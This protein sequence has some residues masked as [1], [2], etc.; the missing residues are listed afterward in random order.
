MSQWCQNFLD[1]DNLELD[2]LWYERLAEA[3]ANWT[4]GTDMAREYYQRALQLDNPSWLCYRGLGKTYFQQNQPKEA[5]AQVQ[6]A[7]DRAKEKGATPEPK[8][9]DIVN[10]HLLL[11]QY[12]EEAED[13]Q[14]ATENFSIACERGSEDADQAR[15]AKLGL[16]KARLKSADVESTREWLRETPILDG[17]SM[18]SI[19]RTIALDDDPG[20]ILSKLFTVAKSDSIL[21]N[22]IVCALETATAGSAASLDGRPKKPTE[23]HFAEVEA[24]GVLLYYRG[25]AAYTMAPVNREYVGEALRLWTECRHLLS[26]VGGSNASLARRCSTTDLAKHYFQ[27]MLE[28]K[29]KDIDVTALST[30][31]ES[32]SGF[33][34]S[35]ALGFLGALYAMRGNMDESKKALRPKFDYAIQILEDDTP[36]NDSWGFLCLQETLATHCDFKNSA[37]ALSFLCQPDLVT[38]ALYFPR[39]GSFLKQYPAESGMDGQQLLSVL[40]ALGREINET[41][42]KQVPDSSQQAQRI[43]TARSY[44][45]SLQDA[46]EKSHSGKSG[47][48]DSDR[49]TAAA[50]NLVKQR[51]DSLAHSHMT[52]I[53]TDHFPMP[54]SCDGRT[55]DGRHC[56]KLCSF[57]DTFYVCVYCSNK[58]LCEDCLKRLR[59]SRSS[60]EFAACSPMH[61]WLKVPRYGEKSIV[62]IAMANAGALVHVP[63]VKTAAE[64]EQIFEIRYADNEQGEVIKLRAWKDSLAA[65]WNVG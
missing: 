37:V 41:V 46:V 38:E 43:E 25:V 16:L 60:D 57:G 31:I 51:L 27:D 55:S 64:D 13:L 63:I 36:D 6:M 54:K 52:H 3:A 18:V 7:L 15:V 45:K 11:G 50:H 8:T 34:R 17:T 19:L 30:L 14:R 59:D 33:E 21:W 26:D 22:R 1:L 29:D 47:L 35:D 20:A 24:R 53:D 9:K 32:D 23:E 49:V 28:N 42:Q 39:D 61:K 48:A 40:L 10:L 58:D 2:S 56:R 44:F 5:I 65:E 4:T 12:A 62:S